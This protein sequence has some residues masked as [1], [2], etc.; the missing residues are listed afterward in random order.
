[1]SQIR[2]DYTINGVQS[3]CGLK[4]YRNGRDVV[5]ILSD[6]LSNPGYSITNFKARL[7][8]PKKV[9]RSYALKKHNTRF[10]ERL[11]DISEKHI[12]KSDVFWEIEYRWRGHEPIA[13][14]PKRLFQVN[15]M[16][17]LLEG[18]QCSLMD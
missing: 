9:I 7:L 15:E 14:N 11:I 10:F 3:H 8:L 13:A 18:Y 1:V 4:I 12:R 17:M 6:E 2:L 5:V 16:K